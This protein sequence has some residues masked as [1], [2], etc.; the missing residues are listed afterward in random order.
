MGIA[1]NTHNMYKMSDNIFLKFI[2]FRLSHLK[3]AFKNEIE[4]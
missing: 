4:G 1:E 3:S 2:Y